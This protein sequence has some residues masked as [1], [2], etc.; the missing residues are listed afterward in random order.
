MEVGNNTKET[1]IES[2]F[3]FIVPSTL[4]K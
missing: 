2:V 1:R 3:F 4:S